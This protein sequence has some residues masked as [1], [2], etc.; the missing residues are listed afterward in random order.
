MDMPTKIRAVLGALQIPEAELARRIGTS[1]S[2]LHQRMTTGKFRTDELEQ[3]AEALGCKF[4]YYF[5]LPCG[6]KI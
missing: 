2:A 1:P 6:D 4:E 5:I 3:I